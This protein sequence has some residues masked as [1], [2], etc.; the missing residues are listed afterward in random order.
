MLVDPELLNKPQAF[1]GMGQWLPATSG[2]RLPRRHRGQGL[3]PVIDTGSDARHCRGLKKILDGQL[4]MPGLPNAGDELC[5]QNGIAAELEKI[6]VDIH[7]LVAEPLCQKRGKPSLDR[8]LWRLM[9]GPAGLSGRV[10]EG[11]PE[12]FRHANALEFANG[13]LRD[14]VY[15]EHLLRHLK[16]SQPLGGKLTNIAI[17]SRR[18]TMQHHHHCR[19]IFTQSGVRHGKRQRLRHSGMCE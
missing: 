2:S 5:S 6:L 7:P 3:P 10:G 1:L 9:V 15:H 19:H 16:R 11:Q 14:L 4:G 12:F 18:M 17:G 13:T 8:G